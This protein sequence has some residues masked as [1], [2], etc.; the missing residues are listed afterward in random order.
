MIVPEVVKEDD[1]SN[2][3]NDGIWSF[4]SK[5][6]CAKLEAQKILTKNVGSHVFNGDTRH[7]YMP[8]DH[9]LEVWSDNGEGKWRRHWYSVAIP[10]GTGKEQVVA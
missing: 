5:E 6:G 8:E 1:F 2:V 4:V 3:F 9:C 10:E 7:Q